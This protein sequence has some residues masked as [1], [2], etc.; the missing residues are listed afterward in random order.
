MRGFCSYSIF[1]I[2]KKKVSGD[3]KQNRSSLGTDFP[4]LKNQLTFPINSE[5]CRH[6]DWVGST[7][8]LILSV[9]GAKA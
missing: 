5:S 3:S 7:K 1:P 8:E 6:V 4:K 2:L 9:F